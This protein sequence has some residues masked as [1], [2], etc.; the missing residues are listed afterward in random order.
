ME[1]IVPRQS[2][3][4]LPSK[5]KKSVIRKLLSIPNDDAEMHE[6]LFPDSSQPSIPSSPR[7]DNPPPYR[8]ES[9][10]KRVLKSYDIN[11]AVII[12]H[13]SEVTEEFTYASQEKPVMKSQDNPP[14]ICLIFIGFI[15][16]AAFIYIHWLSIP[17]QLQGVSNVFYS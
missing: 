4:K 17:K 11:K 14:L 7:Q 1:T 12:Y 13:D 3:S 16:V 6:L 2:F 10:V 8:K 5:S 9:L 15:I